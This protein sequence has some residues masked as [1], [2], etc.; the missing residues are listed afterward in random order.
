MEEE[1]KIEAPSEETKPVEH[2]EEVSEVVTE[3]ATE[4]VSG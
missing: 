2:V 4:E 3:V 1:V